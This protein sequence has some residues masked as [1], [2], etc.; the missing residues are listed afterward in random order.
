[1]SGDDGEQRYVDET[2]VIMYCIDGFPMFTFEILLA[3]PCS[4]KVIVLC[5]VAKT[6]H[7]SQQS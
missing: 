2:C 3:L 1:M 4:Q 5:F 6:I 7:S